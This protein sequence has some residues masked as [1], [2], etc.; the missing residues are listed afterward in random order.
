MCLNLVSRIIKGDLEIKIHYG[1]KF[2]NKVAKLDGYKDE[3]TKSWKIATKGNPINALWKK[4]MRLQL[5]IRKLS[6]PLVGIKQQIE[7]ARSALK[8]VQ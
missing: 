1:F 5:V 2:I 6:K 7:K 3:V 8:E 4:M